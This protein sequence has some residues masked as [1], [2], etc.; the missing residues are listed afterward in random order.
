MGTA[1]LTHATI[2]RRFIEEVLNTGDWSSA[3]ELLSDDVVM[4]HPSAPEPIRGRDAVQGFLGQFR[5]GMPDLTLAVDDVAGDGDPVAVRWRA[6]GTHSEEMFGIPPT[7]NGIDIHGISFFRFDQ[8]GKIV[9][10]WVE[11]NTLSVLQQ[12]GV[13]PRLG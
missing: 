8:A 10:D 13:V 3:G 7:N 5:A 6:H 2:A 1:A 4:H 9:E 11:E 12:L